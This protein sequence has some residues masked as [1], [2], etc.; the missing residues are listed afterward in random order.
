MTILQADSSRRPTNEGFPAPLPF[1]PPFLFILPEHSSAFAV[2]NVAFRHG[3]TL[4]YLSLVEDLFRDQMSDLNHYISLDEPTASCFA[5]A[6]YFIFY[7][8]LCFKS[9]HIS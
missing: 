4:T 8:A 5:L 3:S 6:V 1:I 2:V 9:R 7:K